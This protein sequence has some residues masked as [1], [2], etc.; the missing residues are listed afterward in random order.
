M[1]QDVKYLLQ[2]RREEA[3]TQRNAIQ[4]DRDT[5]KAKY[6]LVRVDCD[7][8]C[9]ERD[10]YVMTVETLREENG[11]LHE[12]VCVYHISLFVFLCGSVV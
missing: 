9:K 5:V 12:Q 8:L 11:K 6:D 7:K 3:E 2:S 10:H 4:Q 1:E